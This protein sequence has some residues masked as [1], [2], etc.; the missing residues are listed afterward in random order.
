[1]AE[2]IISIA[3]INRP[4]KLRLCE[5]CSHLIEKEPAI[6]L[7]GCA[8]SGDPLWAMYLHL[9]CARASRD[10]KMLASPVINPPQA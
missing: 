1:M 4:R 3:L 9:G 7:Y 6:R 5:D 8:H 10:P 2:G